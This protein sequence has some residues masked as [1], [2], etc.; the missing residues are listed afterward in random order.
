MKKVVW[1][2]MT[3]VAFI[4]LATFSCMKNE[5]AP[6][7]VITL[8]Q[9]G[10]FVV[11]QGNYNYSNSSI[12]FYCPDNG[13]V[14]N[15]VFQKANQMKLGDVAQSMTIYD[16]KAW[17]AVNNSGTI[18]S[19]DTDTALEC[20]RIEGLTSPRYIHILNSN[21]GYITQ[22]YDNRIAIFNPQSNQITG[23]ITVDG[24]DSFNAS[25]ESM[26]QVEDYLFV[27]CWSYQKEILKIDT[28][29]DKIVARKQVGIQPYKIL[30]DVN[31]KIWCYTDGGSWEE[32]PIGFE[33]PKLMRID[34]N[35][36]EIEKEFFF[37]KGIYFADF[38]M[39][40]KGDAILWSDGN[41]WKMGIGAE[42]LPEKPFIDAST[43][44]FLTTMSVDSR[45]GEIYAADCMDYVQ[46]GVVYHFSKD[47]ELQGKFKAGISPV[48]IV[49]KRTTK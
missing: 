40:E 1:N 33:K 43:I 16:K 12:D 14:L 23:Y 38:S 44:G 2:L 10:V 3:F 35:T 39:N 48:H 6:S 13:K 45:T 49:F 27:T 36:L 19:I 37:E 34:A 8:E 15:S 26:T 30:H 41:I 22:M 32:N 29:T 11:N 4:T 20:G 47:G 18:Y 42:V 17:I 28:R 25:T 7:E 9:N 24:M 21:K 31:Q 46:C 5:G